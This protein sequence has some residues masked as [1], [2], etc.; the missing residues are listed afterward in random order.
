[1]ANTTAD[2]ARSLTDAQALAAKGALATNAEIA[3][4]L[5]KM[6]AVQKQLADWCLGI[7]T[8]PQRGA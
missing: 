1:M 5:A 8:E 4:Q 6:A 2:A 3:S 7:M